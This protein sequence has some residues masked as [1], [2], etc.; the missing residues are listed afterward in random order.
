MA[1]PS[2]IVDGVLTDSEAWVGIATT[3]L[4]ADAATVTFTSADD[5]SSLDWSQYMDLV[6]VCYVAS[7]VVAVNDLM[8]TWL[9]GDTTTSNYSY[10]TIVG[11]GRSGGTVEAGSSLVGGRGIDTRRC[12]GASATN[13]F[14][15][16]VMNLFDVNSGKYKSAVA[17]FANDIDSAVEACSVG[18]GTTTWKSQAPI[19]SIVFGM[20]GGDI[21]TGSMFSLFGVLPRMVA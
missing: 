4:G 19:A 13:I 12:A 20:N 9:N 16:I 11:D 10:Q 6:V 14:T 21:A 7:D 1:D 8:L 2:Y 5:G 17:K 15:A 3:T 18:M